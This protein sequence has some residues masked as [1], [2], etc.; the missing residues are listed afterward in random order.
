MAHI[1]V[2]EDHNLLQL[3]LRNLTRRAAV[4]SAAGV[5]KAFHTA[6]QALTDQHI[7]QPRVLVVDSKAVSIHELDLASGATH[8]LT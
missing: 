1:A 7:F 4:Q 6:V 2:L 3:I 8:G 5:C